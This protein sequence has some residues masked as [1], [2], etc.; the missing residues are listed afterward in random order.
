MAR[1]ATFDKLNNLQKISKR[2]TPS[3]DEFFEEMEL[4]R[5]E[6][7]GRINLAYLLYPIFIYLFF[8]CGSAS[9]EVAIEYAEL[10]EIVQRRYTDAIRQYNE[11]LAEDERIKERIAMVSQEIVN[12]TI[13][14]LGDSYFTSQERARL[15][16]ENETNSVANYE[17]EQNAIKQ[18]YTMKTWVSM[19]DERVRKDHATVDGTTIAINDYFDVGSDRM[20]YPGDLSASPEQTINCRCVCEYF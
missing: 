1:L 9:V 5:E 2:K 7:E 3:I 15:I 19:Q 4:P 11:D 14:N 6:I 16:A 18:G 10:Y 20:L 8:V 12:T 13:D 17:R